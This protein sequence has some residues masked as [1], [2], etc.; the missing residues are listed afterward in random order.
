VTGTDLDEYF[1]RLIR[2]VPDFPVAGVMF[3]DITP[4]SPTTPRSQRR[5]GAG[6]R[7]P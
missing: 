1:D 6:R 4:C 5:A 3:K 7:W 2:D